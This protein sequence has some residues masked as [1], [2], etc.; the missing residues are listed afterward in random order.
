MY[1]TPQ[2]VVYATAPSGQVPGI[3]EG[4]ILTQ[5]PTLQGMVPEQQPG[6]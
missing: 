3:P 2:G 4:Y 1:Q 6:Q 5:T